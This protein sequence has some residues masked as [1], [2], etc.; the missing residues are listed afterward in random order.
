MVM[1][2][3][4]T[5]EGEVHTQFHQEPLQP[6]KYGRIQITLIVSIHQLQEVLRI[7]FPEDWNSRRLEVL[8][9]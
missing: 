4:Q 1:R 6:H 8:L 2:F 7:R 9:L 5:N 3:V